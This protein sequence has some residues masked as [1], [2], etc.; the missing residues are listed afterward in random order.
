[1]SYEEFKE[2]CRE[3]WKGEDYNFF[4]LTDLKRKV[5]VNNVFVVTEA[6]FF[7]CVPET[8]LYSILLFNSDDLFN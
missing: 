4:K 5:K 2:L 6:I 7:E 8:N 3:D 1:M